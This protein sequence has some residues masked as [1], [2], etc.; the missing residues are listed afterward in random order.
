MSLIPVWIPSKDNPADEL[1]RN[2]LFRPPYPQQKNQRQNFIDSQP[3][4]FDLCLKVVEG[5]NRTKTRSIVM[6]LYP[7]RT[8]HPRPRWSENNKKFLCA[9]T[10][11]LLEFRN[12]LQFSHRAMI[13][14][15]RLHPSQQTTPC[16]HDRALGIANLLRFKCFPGIG[17]AVVLFCD[18]ELRL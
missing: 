2:I 17:L 6:L 9:V 16:L 12:Q 11:Y 7:S 1:S 8:W 10:I 14:L 3:I 15:A 4:L 5:H 18:C 13:G